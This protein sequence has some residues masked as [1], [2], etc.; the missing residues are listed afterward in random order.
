[1][2]VTLRGGPPQWPGGLRR[3]LV[4]TLRNVLHIHLLFVD[5]WP[6]FPS[7]N[8]PSAGICLGTFS[9]SWTNLCCVDRGISAGPFWCYQENVFFER[10]FCIL[11]SSLGRGL[12][13]V[14]VCHAAGTRLKNWLCRWI[15]EHARD[16]LSIQFIFLRKR[17]GKIRRIISKNKRNWWS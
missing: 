9:I 5:D 8:E 2:V 4:M 11:H 1:M 13:L 10:S 17:Y 16:L 3:A 14:E 7:D 15:K 12:R 6:W